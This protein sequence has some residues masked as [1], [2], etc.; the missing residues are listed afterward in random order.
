MK[1]LI[2]GTT[3][4]IGQEIVNS[5][6]GLQ[7]IELNRQDVDLNDIEAVKKYQIPA[8]DC[9]ILNAGHD[10]GGGSPFSAHK[11]DYITKILT[12]NFMSTVVLCHKILNNNPNA[13]LL[14]VTSTNV[15]WD[16]LGPDQLAYN[17]S[18]HS[19]KTFID[20]L[21]LEY[22]SAQIKEARVGITNTN[23]YAN[24]Y[25]HDLSFNDLKTRVQNRLKK[26]HHMP[27]EYVSSEIIDL[28]TSTKN[29]KEIDKYT[30]P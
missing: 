8:V 22:P 24:K 12:C 13:I 25:K 29:F 30:K 1:V 17:L 5:N 28:L 14:F 15:N 7:F 3:S 27:V 20:L 2:T 4:G 6:P 10:L 21:K 9:A 26:Y 11:L 16:Y 18:K 19:V 23:F